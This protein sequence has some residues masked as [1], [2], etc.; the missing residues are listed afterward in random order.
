MEC[1]VGSS[2]AIS[3]H[4]FLA[5]AQ[6]PGHHSR[7]A[8]HY[9]SAGLAFSGRLTQYYAGLSRKQLLGVSVVVAGQA[10]DSEI[11]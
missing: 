6:Q 4:A 9:R 5:T 7:H 3:S 1:R 11:Y 2:L 10:A 8:A